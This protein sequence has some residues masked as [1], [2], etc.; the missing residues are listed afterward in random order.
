ML[1]DKVV[2][3]SYLVP[4]LALLS[5]CGGGSPVPSQAIA[6]GA[7]IS[8]APVMPNANHYGNDSFIIT[9]QLYGNDA[10]VYKRKGFTVTYDHTVTG[11]AISAPQGTA[12]TPNDYWYLT[13]SGHS[14]VLVYKIKPKKSF[15]QNPS[16]VLDDY[17]E[18]PVNVAATADRNL[19]GV[20]NG[21]TTTNG[22][23]SVSVYLNR[24]S[25]PTRILTYGTDQLQ[26]EGIA[27]D[28]Q[29]DCYW[30][31]NDPNINGG[32]IVEF[33]GCN[34]TGSQVVS[35]ITKAGGVAFDQSGNM[36]YVDQAYGI[37]KCVKTSN[38]KL[39]ADN[40]T[41]GFGQP[42]NLNFDYKEKSLWL[43]DATGYFWGIDLKGKC[44]KG[45]MCVYQYQS[46]DGDPYGIAPSPGG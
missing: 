34:G 39:W 17:G 19:V 44:N 33:A 23:G 37:Y 18:V 3:L 13:N 24:Q 28:H 14:N 26:G 32:A 27:I 41:Y 7:T 36:Y 20:S 22:A 10:T 38:C 42:N 8:D 5:G 9:A 15:P 46:V 21:S 45:N 35:G 31:F 16:N 29:G 4:A 1:V 2:R 11:Y 40:L 25:E 6:T 12:T 30:S 43:S